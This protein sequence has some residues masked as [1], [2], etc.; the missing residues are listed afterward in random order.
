MIPREAKPYTH[1]T[2]HVK[3]TLASEVV[4]EMD[5]ECPTSLWASGNFLTFGLE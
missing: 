2:W 3:D 5:L 4:L 1:F